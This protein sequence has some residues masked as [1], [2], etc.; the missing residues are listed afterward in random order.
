MHQPLA[1]LIQDRRVKP[2]VGQFQAQCIL[3]VDAPTHDIRNL[4]VT[5]PLHEL[6]N[7]HQ[8]QPPWRF[9]WLSG[10]VTNALKELMAL[11]EAR[12]R[13]LFDGVEIAAAKTPTP[14]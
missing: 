8:R 1:E 5:Q 4:S 6:E 9:R 13:L 11:G 3:P 2:I 14:R 10:G 7:K 12:R